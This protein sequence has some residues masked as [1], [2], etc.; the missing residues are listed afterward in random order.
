VIPVIKAGSLKKGDSTMGLFKRFHRITIGRI[1]AFLSRVEDPELVFPVLVKEMEE[2]LEAA[3]EAEAKA[4]ASLKSCEREMNRH[5]GTISRYGSGA[6]LALQ[7]G[8]EQ[9]ARQSVT[10]QIDA[11]KAA[12]LSRR[13]L[14]IAQQSLERA[15]VGRERIQRQLEELRVKKNEILTR[16]RVAKVQKKIQATVSGSA[17]SSDSILDAVARLES[18]VE[19]TEAGIEIQASLAGEAAACPS[20]EEK[21]D[22]L[23]RD[24]E[25]EARLA[26]LREQAR[27]D[28]DV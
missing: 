2:Q 21:L 27:H 9:T 8:D 7:R 22:E 6:L 5:T 11:E 20:L 18:H 28:A 13:N 16:A 23:D 25:I 15:R 10:A 12:E 17:G 19:Q 14:E 3:A 26:K 4:T 24:A 1:E